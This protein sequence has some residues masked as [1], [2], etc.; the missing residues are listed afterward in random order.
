MEGN[1]FPGASQSAHPQPGFRFDAR[2]L[3]TWGLV[4]LITAALLVRL[5][6]MPAKGW[7]RD[8]DWFQEWFHAAVT[9]GVSGVATH[10]WCDYPPVYLY[11]LKGV[12]IA[13]G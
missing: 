7:E 8:L 1:S 4:A 11:V 13:Y 6:W 2:V 3:Q 12:G 9:H 10:V 5:W